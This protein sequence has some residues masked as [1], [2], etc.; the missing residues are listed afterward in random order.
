MYENLCDELLSIIPNIHWDVE[1]CK[2]IK[3]A[4]EILS[5]I[6]KEGRS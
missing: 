1:G 2:A 3:Q 6:Q 5:S 4:V